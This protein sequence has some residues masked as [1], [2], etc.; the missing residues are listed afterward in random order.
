MGQALLSRLET[1]VELI[2]D[3]PEMEAI[4]SQRGSGK[5]GGESEDGGDWYYS[6][7][8]E[9]TDNH[10]QS[11][12]ILQHRRANPKVKAGVLF[13][14]F[15]QDRP[16]RSHLTWADTDTKSCGSSWRRSR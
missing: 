7:D 16:L 3:A 11:L 8:T 12:T 15:S 13:D 14:Q 6:V 5:E 4:P 10:P 2:D 9:E 1:L